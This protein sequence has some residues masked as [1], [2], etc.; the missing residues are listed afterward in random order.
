MPSFGKPAVP[1]A[2][3][4]KDDFDVYTRLLTKKEFGRIIGKS[5]GS[6]ESMMRAGFPYLKLGRSV[7]FRL[8]DA[9]KALA[10]FTVTSTT[11]ELS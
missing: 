11:K 4:L 9:E 8:R 1:S 7:R 6:V 2:D 3:K 5:V 10:A